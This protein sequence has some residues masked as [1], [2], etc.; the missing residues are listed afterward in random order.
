MN[1]YNLPADLPFADTLAAWLLETYPDNLTHV[2]VLLPTRRACRNLQDAF[3]RESDGKPVLLPRMQPLGDVEENELALTLADPTLAEKIA[4]LEP[5]MPQ[6]KRRF[7]LTQLV[8]KNPLVHSLDQALQLADS[9]ARL[10]DQIHTEE[11][12]FAQLS[13]LIDE[14]ELQAHWQVTLKF[15]EII[16]EQWPQILEEQGYIEA[17]HRRAILMDT[18]AESWKNEPPQMPVIAAG[19]T[20]SI[21]ATSRLLARVASLPNGKLILPGLD[22]HMDM[23]SWDAVAE[24]HPQFTLK[25]LLEKLDIDRKAVVSFPSEYI[26]TQR[27]KLASEIMRPA[28][29]AQRWQDISL[30]ESAT[31]G[32]SRIDCASAEEEALVISL[33]LRRALEKPDQTAA[34]VSPDRNLAMRV[35]TILR[36][37]DIEIDD[38]AGVKLSHTPIGGWLLQTA[39]MLAEYYAPIP[40]LSA[41]KHGLSR[42]DWKPEILKLEEY[43]LRG[44]RPPE[45]LHGLTAALDRKV[46]EI[47]Q[48]GIPA[49]DHEAFRP[50]LNE[51]FI[52]AFDD[53]ADTYAD[54]PISAHLDTHLAL[55][56]IL[57]EDA[58]M[59]WSGDAGEQAALFLASIREEAASL[60][61][62]CFSDYT[63]I[64]NRLMD[65]ITIRP[66]FGK[67]SRL[68]IL[69]QLEARMVSADVL[70]LS[71][72]N[73][74]T[75]PPDPG[76]DPWMSRPMKRDFGLPQPERGIGLSAHDF[77]QSLHGQRVYMTRSER[78]DGAP[79][80]ASRWLSRLD[81]VLEGANLPPITEE[82]ALWKSFADKLLETDPLPPLSAPAPCP[83]VSARPRQLSVTRIGTWMKDPYALYAEKILNLKKLDDLEKDADAAA[84]GTAI[85]SA[86]EHFMAH[87]ME[88]GWPDNARTLLLDMGKDAFA[89]LLDD[90]AKRA[91]W[92]PRFERAADWFLDTQKSW[93]KDWSPALLEQ[94][95]SI[96]FETQTSPFTLTAKADR[97]DHSKDGRSAAILDY[98]TGSPP[99][100]KDIKNGLA[101]QLTLTGG[102]ILKGGFTSLKSVEEIGTLEH[103]KLNGTGDGGKRETAQTRKETAQDLSEEAL[104]G[105]QSLIAAFDDVTT[106]YACMPH[107]AEKVRYNDY[108]HLER[109]TEWNR[110][111]GEDD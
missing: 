107:G 97:I 2:R 101:P 70:I 21:P 47:T 49:P 3:L 42:H 94:Q 24:G 19:S 62:I 98:K 54:A 71:A 1:V 90:P 61:P 99:T 41:L 86:L 85:H 15:L 110:E 75:W 88:Q 25:L 100:K 57:A 104:D 80:I 11:L 55:L 13:S 82:A 14:Q 81:T 106:P 45:G 91:H 69:G 4:D 38:S 43:V 92:W 40:L 105:L 22:T 87:V 48:R 35:A 59:L 108:D 93:Q 52:P 79:T 39:A 51:T 84:R 74:G 32:L 30:E 16:T 67:H 23:D 5:A 73:E 27:S 63:A 28:E 72:L 50:W 65:G 37:W 36:R 20:G 58:E 46:L 89:G 83:P 31:D 77:T 26:P 96:S 56:D 76:N 64:L 111:G 68:A 109:L 6:M 78:L 10:M 9:L 33:I 60:P 103:W 17:T 12:D 34:L 29:T 7:L 102:I 44:P 53:L 95:G 66:R 8:L 18:L